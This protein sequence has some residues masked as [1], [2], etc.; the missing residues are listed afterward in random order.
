M[1]DMQKFPETAE[2][3]MEEHKL[4]DVKQ[5]YSGGTEFVPIFRMKQW[6][7]HE[8]AKR[9]DVDDLYLLLDENEH[10]ISAM[11]LTKDQ[12]TG[13]EQVLD[14]VERCGYEF[15]LV[16]AVESGNIPDFRPKKGES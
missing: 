12:A 14:I 1:A 9:G 8:K 11:Y 5:V 6:F 7:E 13:I 3:F 16:S 10:V 2:E 4:V 15:T